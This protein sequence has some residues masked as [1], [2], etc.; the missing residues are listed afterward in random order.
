MPKVSSPKQSRWTLY[1]TKSVF[2][3]ADGS[4][5]SKKQIRFL[6]ISRDTGTA[7]EAVD[8]PENLKSKL[9]SLLPQGISSSACIKQ[10]TC[11]AVL[12]CV[13]ADHAAFLLIVTESRV[14]VG[15]DGFEVREVR[16]CDALPF[17]L[18]GKEAVG[19]AGI[20]E[21]FERNFYFSNDFDITRSLQ[22][23]RAW[24]ETHGQRPTV[25][26]FMVHADERF[27]W[28]RRLA[29][30]LMCQNGVSARWFTPVVQGFVEAKTCDVSV[31]R[32]KWVLI[33]I[34]RKSCRH[35]GTRY[36]ARGLDDDG[37][38]ANWIE[39][40]QIAL[41]PEGAW[42]SFIQVRGSA[43]VFW[44]QS[45]GKAAVNLTRGPELIATGFDKHRR[46]VEAEYGQVVFLSLLSRS[47]TK[48]ATEGVLVDA[49]DRQQRTQRDVQFVTVDFHAR[50][51][52]FHHG[53]DIDSFDGRL[54]AVAQEA[55]SEYL[56]CFGYFQAQ[57]LPSVASEV[58]QTQTGVIRT[59][60]FDCL[61]R[62]NMLQSQ[63]AW[64][65]LSCLCRG[66]GGH[67]AASV[68]HARSPRLGAS[69]HEPACPKKTAM[70]AI[71][72]GMWADLGDVLSELYTGASSTMGA[73]LRQGGSNAMSFLEM[74]WATVNRAI[75]AHFGDEARQNALRLALGPQRL[76]RAPRPPEVRRTP[77]G[78]LTVAVVTWNMQGM[79]CWSTPGALTTMLNG[80][81]SPLSTDDRPADVVVLCFQEIV[82]LSPANVVTLGEGNLELQADLDCAVLTALKAAQREVFVKV[83]SM[84]MV[85]VY[86]GIFVADRLRTQVG[87]VAGKRVRTGF[88]GQGNKGAVVLRLDVAATS[89]A[90]ISLHLESGVGKSV[91]RSSQLEEALTTTFVSSKT[92]PPLR[93][94]DLL[95]LGGDFNYR[96]AVPEGSEM[97]DSSELDREWT[98]AQTDR[99]IGCIGEGAAVPRGER[100]KSATL[101]EQYDEICGSEGCQQSQEILQANGLVEG[102]VLFP[103]TYRMLKGSPKY[104][105]ERMPAWTD[106][107]FHSKVGTSRRR[108]CALG[109]LQQSDH[110]PVCAL[111]E[112]NLLAYESTQ[113]NAKDDNTK[114]TRV[115]SSPP[116]TASTAPRTA[117]ASSVALPVP[118][119]AAGA[120]ATPQAVV[121]TAD[122]G[123]VDTGSLTNLLGGPPGVV[124]VTSPVVASSATMSAPSRLPPA[125][126]ATV[127]G[128]T[129]GQSV[130]AH[131]R[132]GW[133][134]ATVTR[135]K[136]SSCDVAWLRP[137]GDQMVSQSAMCRYMC[138]TGEDETLHGDGLPIA[139][140]IRLVDGSLVTPLADGFVATAHTGSHASASAHAAV[141][142]TAAPVSKNVAGGDGGSAR[143]SASGR[144]AG[145]MKLED[146]LADGHQ[147]LLS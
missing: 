12:G 107:V 88:L 136:H 127:G 142:P 42:F 137:R 60:C 118:P 111:L 20:R 143:E 147:D 51:G 65:W 85:G 1:S 110:R 93:N 68:I 17:A 18:G 67:L 82:K 21:L 38:A 103:P 29:E 41:T 59:N 117:T 39:T 92:I 32:R 144:S 30:P 146:L 121:S 134:L 126:P 122:I 98:E 101:L 8:S 61:D 138:S 125:S 49:L 16:R 35:A 80:A 115:A 44:E 71:V 106:R 69:F 46:L 87:G 3:I 40:E 86:T 112:T 50:V 23:Q 26:H 45:S 55:V 96:L 2:V 77:F 7:K 5:S 57:E 72:R 75:H 76:L 141:A 58:G 119:V 130:I 94:H 131:F 95:V 70:R 63:M 114:L 64:Q 9:E 84:G 139:T 13:V 11:E 19:V 10:Q 116:A 53:D 22:R 6:A 14:V 135:V 66:V 113:P 33:L 91:D 37:E 31:D 89:L 52:N 48:Q 104:D 102:P 15:I 25:E 123:N 133:Y 28:N 79:A 27:V 34:A 83:L 43:P 124:T 97:T 120:V 47:S 4:Q 81:C 56:H 128:L 24:Q 100:L 90:A 78:R 99:G 108:Y 109:G 62:T 36:N 73:T 105:T 74:G 145:C 54:E 132:G 129:T 140:H